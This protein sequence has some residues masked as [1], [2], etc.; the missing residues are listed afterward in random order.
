MNI[1]E[2]KL[3]KTRSQSF[4]KAYR[5]NQTPDFSSGSDFR[6]DALIHRSMNFGAPLKSLVSQSD[7]YQYSVPGLPLKG[8]TISFVTQPP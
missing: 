2:K 4:E 3:S 1:E 5:L 8:P 6:N 7:D